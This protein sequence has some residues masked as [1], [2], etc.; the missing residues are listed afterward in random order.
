MAKTMPTAVETKHL[1]IERCPPK[2][3]FQDSRW[4]TFKLPEQ[5]SWRED[6]E[7]VRA[8][9]DAGWRLARVTITWAG[10]EPLTPARREVKARALT[11]CHDRCNLILIGGQPGCGRTVFELER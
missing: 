8:L 1:T 2:R 5:R 3:L 6:L 10:S 11:G 7:P 9:M 4:R